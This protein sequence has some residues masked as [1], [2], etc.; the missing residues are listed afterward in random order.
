MKRILFD[1]QQPTTAKTVA[2]V[3]AICLGVCSFALSYLLELHFDHLQVFEQFNVL[4]NTDPNTRLVCFSHGW[5]GRGLV[6]PNLANFINPSIRA[7]AKTLHS[8]GLIQSDELAIRRQLG[9]FVVPLASGGKT[10]LML[11]IWYYM[12]LK[13]GYVLLLTLLSIGSF[14]HIIF[15][16]IPDHFG[17]SGFIIAGLFCLFI[18]AVYNAGYVRK[19][20]WILCGVMLFGITVTNIIPYILLLFMVF[21]WSTGYKLKKSLLETLKIIIL[22]VAI[23]LLYAVFFNW[24]WKD[25]PSLHK[26]I[27][28][29]MPYFHSNISDIVDNAVRFPRALANTI[30]PSKPS[31]VKNPLGIKHNNKYKIMFSYEEIF[32]DVKDILILGFIICGAIGLVMNEHTTRLITFSAFAV[33]I[34]NWGLHSLYGTELFLYSQHWQVPLMIFFTGMFYFTRTYGLVTKGSIALLVIV[35][36]INNLFILRFIMKTLQ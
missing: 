31:V 27:E 15:G 13:S 3:L 12:G 14:S 32:I 35:S 21:R 34:Y 22:V 17:L 26:E 4:F 28:R 24:L 16:S 10:V 8:L 11:F 33:I 6:H 25:S 36:M 19:P 2:I 23:T 29:Q 5:G 18:E 9:L 7:A 20:L 30:L 1:R